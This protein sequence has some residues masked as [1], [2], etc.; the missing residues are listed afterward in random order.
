MMCPQTCYFTD[1]NYVEFDEEESNA[2]ESNEE[3]SDND[4]FASDEETECSS[5]SKTNKMQANN[6]C[7]TCNF[8]A[9]KASGLKLHMSKDH[10]IKCSI[11]GF[12]TT[13][14][15]LLKKHKKEFHIFLI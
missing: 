13:T 12:K 2:E 11:C 8:E 7:S 9:K 14:D 15:A 6:K 4:N 5:L 10:K 1:S 3:E